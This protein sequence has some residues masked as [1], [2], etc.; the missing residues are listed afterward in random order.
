LGDEEYSGTDRSIKLAQR[1]AAQ[2]AIDDL[3]D[4]INEARLTE[5]DGSKNGSFFVDHRSM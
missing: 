4:E 5:N 1:A 2:A 3:K